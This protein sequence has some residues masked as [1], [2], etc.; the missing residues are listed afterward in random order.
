MNRLPMFAAAALLAA[1]A[2]TNEPSRNEAMFSQVRVGMTNDEIRAA[3]GPPDETMPFPRLQSIAWDYRYTD[4]WGYMAVYSVTF[5]PDSR[6]AS[7]FSRRIN[8]GG[9]HGAR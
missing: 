1:C 8:Q 5:G 3:L 4:A 2:T 9:D 7:T 6:V